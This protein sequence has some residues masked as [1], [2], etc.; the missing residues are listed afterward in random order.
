MEAEEK[1]PTVRKKVKPE[2]PRFYEDGHIN[3][4]SSLI[5]TKE[6]FVKAWKNSKH[7]IDLDAAWKKAEKWRKQFK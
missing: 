4:L 2:A 7:R 3:M 6:D 1:K 5:T